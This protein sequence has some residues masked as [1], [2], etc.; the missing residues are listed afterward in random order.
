M[1]T[2]RMLSD[3]TADSVARWPGPVILE[4]RIGSFVSMA[5]STT[6]RPR[7]VMSLILLKAP[8]GIAP[9]GHSISRSDVE[10]S[11][12]PNRSG[13]LA[14]TIVCVEIVFFWASRLRMR[15]LGLAVQPRLRDEYREQPEQD[16]EADHDE[17]ADAHD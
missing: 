2:A 1:V 16:G 4:D 3:T 13:L 14:T 17:C 15:M 8:F 9:S 6:R 12:A 10:P 5:V 11:S 7:E